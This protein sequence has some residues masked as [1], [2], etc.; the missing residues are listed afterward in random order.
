L[1]YFKPV[2]RL[3]KSREEPEEF[4]EQLGG[5][6]WGLP[7]DR[8]PLCK[9]CSSPMTFLAQLR[10]HPVRLNLGKEGRILYL[11]LC[12]NPSASCDFWD[13]E[14]GSNAVV[15]LEKTELVNGITN[16]PES[17]PQILVDFQIIRWELTD[18]EIP[19]G[20]YSDF[21]DYKQWDQLPYELREE[22][23]WETRFGGTPGWVQGP[24]H[25]PGFHYTGQL[26]FLEL[27][28]PIPETML[29]QTVIGSE[30]YFYITKENR[31]P[32][33]AWPKNEAKTEW[34]VEIADFGDACMGFLLIQPDPNNPSGKLSWQYI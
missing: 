17:V 26:S 13:P 33:V 25:Y 23:Q 11:F 3:V 8:W 21:F 31:T 16:P 15:I 14:G 29:K 10:H 18:D 28:Q 1:K 20:L 7:I 5:V 2:V 19:P 6:P 24:E 12:L 9:E 32:V 22:L 30:T 27:A 34:E 4:T